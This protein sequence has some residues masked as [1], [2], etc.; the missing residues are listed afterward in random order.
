MV[1]WGNRK[2]REGVGY[3]VSSCYRCGLTVHIVAEQK[4]KFTLYFIPIFTY[5]HTAFLFCSSC[6]AETELSGD[7]A[8]EA[9]ANA[10]PQYMLESMIAKAQAD[11][12]TTREK[13]VRML[14]QGKKE[15]ALSNKKPANNSK[16]KK[17]PAATSTKVKPLRR[18][19]PKK[20]KAKKSSR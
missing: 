2:K 17:N 9:L 14:A 1:I 12:V 15:T 18:A 16:A 11:A 20:T 19:A 10:M 8:N 13:Q 5:S 3:T 7:K 6:G 4:S